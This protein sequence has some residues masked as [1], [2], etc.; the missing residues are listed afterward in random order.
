MTVSNIEL[1]RHERPRIQNALGILISV[2]MIGGALLAFLVSSSNFSGSEFEYRVRMTM[3]NVYCTAYA[4]FECMLIGAII[5][6]I[7]AA[8]HI[9]KG[10]VD[11]IL[12][13]GCGFRKDIG[14]LPP[15]LRG[16]VDQAITFWKETRRRREED[17]HPGPLRRS[18]ARQVMAEADAMRNYL[19]SQEDPG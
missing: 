3:Q 18:G 13:L 19:L 12:I 2:M 4:Y 9:P 1:L 14:T 16:R 6:G 8:R 5:C 15:L 17:G 10:P 11:Y 7:K